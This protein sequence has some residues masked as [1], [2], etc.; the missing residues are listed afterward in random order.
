[1]KKTRILRAAAGILA[2]ILLLCTCIC[3]A[4]CEKTPDDGPDNPDNP[5]NPENPEDP[6]DQPE[7]LKK[8]EGDAFTISEKTLRDKT[9]GSWVAQMVGVTW[10]APTEF[11]FC[12]T[13]I[14]ESGVPTWKASMVNDAFGQDDLY[15]EIPFIDAM[16][17]H[18]VGCSLDVMGEY[19]RDSKFGLAHA[20]L[21]GRENLRAGFTARESGDYR[22]NYHADDI[23]WQIEADFLGN[24]YPGMTSE[25]AARAFEIGHIMNYGDG[26]YGGV[27]IAAMHAAAFTTNDLAE[28]IEAGRQAIPAG[29]KF[30][31]VI[32]DV[33]ASYEAG[34]SW[35]KCWHLIED[36]WGK[37]DKCPE[38]SGVQNIDAKINAAYILMGLLWGEGDLEETM[39]ISMR[40][41]QDSDC[42]PS[43]SAAILGTLYG[44]SG[45]P[46]KYVSEVHYDTNKFSYTDYTLDDCID[47]SV[48]LAKENMERYGFTK[49]NGN[50][51]IVHEKKVEPVTF[52]QWPDDELTVYMSVTPRAEGK[53]LIA[54]QYVLPEGY[55]REN[56]SLSFDMGDGMTLPMEVSSY[57]Y[58]E[59]GK[60]TITCTAK[61]GN[62]TAVA[63]REVEIKTAPGGRGFMMTP[64]CS[65]K[66]PTGGGNR[67]ISVIADGLIPQPGAASTEQYDTFTGSS[68]TSAWFA[69][70]F[71]HKVTVTDVLFTEGEHFNNGGWFRKTPKI[72]L[73]IDGQWKETETTF[74]PLYIEVND[75]S[76]QGAPYETF[77][78]TLTT[79]TV[80]EGVRVIGTPGGSSTFVSCAEL[81]VRYSEVENPT[82]DDDADSIEERS[83]LILSENSP[84]GA[85]CK[86]PE[87]IRDGKIPKAGESHTTVQYDTFLNRADDHEDYFGYIFRGTYEISA[88]KFTDGAHFGNGGWFKDGEIWVEALINGK[89]EIVSAT[90]DPKYPVSDSQG[91]FPTYRTY[92]FTLTTPTECQGI[93]IIGAAGGS[94]HFTSISELSVEGVRV[95]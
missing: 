25:A 86:D 18:G 13:I 27:Y 78:F 82:Y 55:D 74:S 87:I 15:V 24:I 7:E 47:L 73:L 66:N 46:G 19:F 39:R 54:T 23:D 31:A 77:T 5:E 63:K 90:V 81:D 49:E 40:G 10:G 34:D 50:W 21:L 38:F 35:E 59:S 22:Y 69:L 37:T 53:I 29:T 4:S 20:N 67:D 71:D 60:Y 83:I 16:K 88:V 6:G 14:P 61:V 26:V 41:G 8:P 93:R 52:E 94:A 51:T 57:Q 45:L 79:P 91:S 84:S 95:Q 42:N 2:L 3:F 64:S 11:R 28:V 76:A 72:E 89:W 92:T 75:M 32:D 70:N 9:A 33:T 85:G 30:R 65:E 68:A 62:H 12:G 1:M 43:S 44:L 80:C 56:L 58:F 17:D 36:K 48:K